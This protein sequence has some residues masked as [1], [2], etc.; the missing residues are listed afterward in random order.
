MFQT[1]ILTILFFLIP[2]FFVANEKKLFDDFNLKKII[3]VLNKSLIFQIILGIILGVASYYLDGKNNADKSNLF[4]GI[5]IETF[6]YFST[7]GLFYYLPAL[8]FLNLISKIFK[9]K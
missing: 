6:I 9:K 5:L 7:I 2:I 3:R 8:L 1:I 4:Y